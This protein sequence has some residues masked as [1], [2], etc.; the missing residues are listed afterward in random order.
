[1]VNN[2]RGAGLVVVFA[3][4]R[5]FAVDDAVDP[6]IQ[7]IYGV[8]DDLSNTEVSADE[9]TEQ[10]L[11]NEVFQLNAD[12][13]IDVRVLSDNTVTNKGWFIDFDVL[14]SSGS[15]VEF[16]GEKAV[17]TLQLRGDTVFANTII[18]LA[19]SCDSPSGG[20]SLALDPQTGTAGNVEIFDF[21]ID[22]EFDS[23]DS[24]IVQNVKKIIVGSRF[25]SSPLD[26]T[27]FNDYRIT[28]MSDTSVDSIRV[29]TEA[30]QALLGRQSWR[31]VEL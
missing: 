27:F 23:E 2:E 24:I 18:P 6:R 20:F 8:V 13:Q 14:D 4:G 11:T 7:S 30:N 15:I 25:D 31:E 16:P 3:T 19:L 12:E 5:F 22:G 1:V 21:N 26:S 28:Q 10:V 29:N 17:R 9:L